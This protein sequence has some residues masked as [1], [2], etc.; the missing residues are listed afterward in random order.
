MAVADGKNCL[1]TNRT[2]NMQ[3]GKGSQCHIRSSD[4][5][6]GKQGRT[7]FFFQINTLQIQGPAF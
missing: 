4:W 2:D 7:E 3:I 5:A 6:N 1:V